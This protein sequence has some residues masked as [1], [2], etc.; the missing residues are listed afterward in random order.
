VPSVV[1][2][3]TPSAWSTAIGVSFDWAD[4]SKRV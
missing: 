2:K 4:Q 1:K 3:Y